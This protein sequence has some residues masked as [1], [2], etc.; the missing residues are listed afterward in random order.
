MKEQLEALRKGALA[1]LATLEDPKQL[2]EFRVRLLGKKGEV[3]ALLRGMGA[4]PAEER[5][6]MGQLINQL[7]SELETALEE[8]EQ[9]VSSRLK[10]EKRKREGKRND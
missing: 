5:P 8:R 2:E 7:R 3:T 4:I 9:T 10:D 6:R 1:E